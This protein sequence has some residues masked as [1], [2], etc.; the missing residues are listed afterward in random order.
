MKKENFIKALKAVNL[1]S[2][3]TQVELEEKEL[4][5]LHGENVGEEEYRKYEDSQELNDAVQMLKEKL[6]KYGTKTAE[7]MVR[8]ANAEGV[9]H[10]TSIASM[11]NVRENTEKTEENKNRKTENGNPKA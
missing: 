1:I 5:M 4:E 9:N 8:G 11:G 10:T 2:K 3:L 7:G 6:R